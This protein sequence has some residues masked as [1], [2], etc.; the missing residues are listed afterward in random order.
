[1]AFTGELEHLP[2]VDVIQLINS[3]RKSGLLSV[4]GRKGES[5]LVFKDGYIV[6]ASHLNNSVKIGQVLVDMGM[7]TGEQL[8]QG[9]KKQ[10]LDGEARKPLAITLIDMGLLTEKDAYKALQHLIEMTLVEILTWKTGKFT[11]QHHDEVIDCEFRYYPE[12]MN[13][14][15]NLNT[16]SILMD[17]LRIFDEKKRDGLIDEEDESEAMAAIVEELISA[18]DLGL[19]EMDEITASLPKAFSATA[20]FDPVI[21]QKTRIAELAPQLPE[22]DVEKLASALAGHTLS[23]GA[24]PAK[25]TAQLLVIIST[26]NL[27]IHSLEVLSRSV[28]AELKAFGSVEEFEAKAKT[29]MKEDAVLRTIIDAPPNVSGASKSVLEL[30]KSLSSRFQGAVMVQ[31]V[32][33]QSLGFTLESYRS[34]VRTV[35]PKPRLQAGSPSAADD[36][37]GLVN[38]L[39]GH[40]LSR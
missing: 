13:N 23:P 18:D 8:E 3:S 33:G 27:L 31:L 22:S 30:Q 16:Q 2:I 10:Q 32:Q 4:K 21:F 40:I 35:L 24:E 17:A 1:M 26:D 12:K 7:L 36:F 11:L 34:G 25:E 29:V 14:E 19:T 37:I 9:L 5:Q 28:G 15:V 20:A 39:P 38:F 6:S